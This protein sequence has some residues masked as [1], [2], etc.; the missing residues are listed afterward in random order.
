MRSLIAEETAT[1]ASRTTEAGTVLL[2]M[3]PVK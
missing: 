3:L 2:V 1:A